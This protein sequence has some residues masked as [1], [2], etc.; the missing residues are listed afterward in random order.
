MV[1]KSMMEVEESGTTAA[2]ITGAIFTFRSARPSSLKIE[3]TRP[4]LLTLMED[5]HILFVGKVTRP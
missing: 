3:F 2:A 5:S 4:F 1:H